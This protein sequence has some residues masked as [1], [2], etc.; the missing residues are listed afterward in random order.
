[1]KINELTPLLSDDN[2]IYISNSARQLFIMKVYRT[3]LLEL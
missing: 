1:M 3:V 2:I